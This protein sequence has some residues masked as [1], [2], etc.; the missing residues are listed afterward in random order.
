MGIFTELGV[1]YAKYRPV[2]CLGWRRTH[3][4]CIEFCLSILLEMAAWLLLLDASPHTSL[5][6]GTA[7]GAPQA[8]LHAAQRA[9]A[10]PRVRG[11][12]AVEGAHLP[13]SGLRRLEP[14]AIEGRGAPLHR[15]A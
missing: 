15:P 1:L 7:D 11:A 2:S 4:R 9:P 10:H 12:G 14:A 6:A 8:L 5:S 3:V 13:V